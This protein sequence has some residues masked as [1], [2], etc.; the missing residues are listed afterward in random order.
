M[1]KCILSTITP[2][3]LYGLCWES[4]LG[5]VFEW[6]ILYLQN[7]LL[8]TCTLLFYVSTSSLY[9]TYV[10]VHVFLNLRLLL[11]ITYSSM[12]YFIS[13]NIYFWAKYNNFSNPRLATK[14][15]YIAEGNSLVACWVKLHKERQFWGNDVKCHNQI[16]KRV[17]VYW[18]LWENI[19]PGRN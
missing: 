11:H 9:T 13:N 5:L 7:Y 3:F 14:L 8:I 19:W 12:A 17:H 16:P 1:N 2:N 15:K 18:R 10:L 6:Q 4:N